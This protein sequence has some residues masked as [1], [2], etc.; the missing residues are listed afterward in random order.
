M[1]TGSLRLKSDVCP[2]DDIF[3]YLQ[4]FAGGS[5]RKNPRREVAIFAV[6]A[7]LFERCDIFEQPEGELNDST[8]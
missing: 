5:E 1:R 2:P 4:E 3:Q 8:I 7:Y 6:L